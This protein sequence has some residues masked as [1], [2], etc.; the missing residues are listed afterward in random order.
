MTGV[1]SD[2]LLV[3]YDLEQV[4]ENLIASVFSLQMCIIIVL[5]L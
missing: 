3:V 2:C 4:T 1:N 5:F